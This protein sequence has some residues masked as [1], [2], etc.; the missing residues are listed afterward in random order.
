M[1][2][3]QRAALLCKRWLT[4][5]SSRVR[6]LVARGSSK[7]APPLLRKLNEITAKILNTPTVHA[8]FEMIGVSPLLMTPQQ[9]D[10]MMRREMTEYAPI[11]KAGREH[12]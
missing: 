2:A 7:T 9:F 5:W 1:C 11:I 8:N 3:K 12:P 4:F 6:R 10:E